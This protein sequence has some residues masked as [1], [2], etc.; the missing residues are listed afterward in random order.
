MCC[1]CFWRLFLH[2]RSAAYWLYKYIAQELSSDCVSL[3]FILFV[4]KLGFDWYTHCMY[5]YCLL[6]QIHNSLAK[7]PFE[8]VCDFFIR[9]INRRAAIQST[10]IESE[11]CS[12]SK[13]AISITIL[14]NCRQSPTKSL[15]RRKFVSFANQRPAICFQNSEIQISVNRKQ[16]FVTFKHHK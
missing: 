3:L 2:A 14:D 4:L 12:P 16:N 15:L 5:M 6:I 10:S 13:T 11:I 9:G 1:W 8:S 7:D